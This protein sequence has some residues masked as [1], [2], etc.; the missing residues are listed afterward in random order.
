MVRNTKAKHQSTNRSIRSHNL[1]SIG[2]LPIEPFRA[3]PESQGIIKHSIGF[4]SYQKGAQ[5]ANEVSIGLSAT[6]PTG[7]QNELL[8]AQAKCIGTT[9]GNPGKQTG[10]TVLARED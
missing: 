5:L 10:F 6:F 7:E 4:N 3:S 9:S 1:G 2:G 8:Q